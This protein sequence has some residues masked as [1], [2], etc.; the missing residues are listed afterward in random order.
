M[1]E[2]VVARRGCGGWS[3]SVQLLVSPGR[4][5]S[6]SGA[7]RGRQNSQSRLVSLQPHTSRPAVVWNNTC[8]RCKVSRVTGRRQVTR[9]QDDHLL[10]AGRGL[11]HRRGLHQDPLQVEG[12]LIVTKH[13][14]IELEFSN[15]YLNSQYRHLP[16]SAFCLLLRALTILP[17]NQDLQGEDT[18][19]HLLL[20]LCTK[21][22]SMY[23]DV[24]IGEHYRSSTSDNTLAS[25]AL[26]GKWTLT[27]TSKAL[28]CSKE[29]KI[30]THVQSVLVSFPTKQALKVRL[31]TW[32][33][34]F[35][36]G[37]PAES[38]PNCQSFHAECVAAGGR[39]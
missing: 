33:Y 17:V 14:A 3:V 26:T 6:R 39:V 36:D 4:V 30:L 16:T 7:G 23:T 21:C 32:I 11:L 12:R 37:H 19:S 22:T 10:P 13:P 34:S 20:I 28:C 18:S 24:T 38:W 35:W 15:Y 5:T 29:T 1:Y 31:W 25:S 2:H 27:K 9:P 8:Y